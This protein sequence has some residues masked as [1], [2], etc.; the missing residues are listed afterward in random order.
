MALNIKIFPGLYTITQLPSDAPLPELNQ[1]GRFMAMM[2][3]MDEL[4]I[5]CEHRYA[6][7]GIRMEAGWRLLMVNEQLEFS[8]V[9]ILADLS[10]ILAD[11]GVSIFVVSTYNTD[12]ILIKQEQLDIAIHVLRRAGHLLDEISQ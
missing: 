2:R 10:S 12:Y 6:P 11:A 4:S 9:G 5:I 1:E 3:T 8:L 7:A